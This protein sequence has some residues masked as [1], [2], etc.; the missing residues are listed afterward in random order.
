MHNLSMR[1][2]IITSTNLSKEKKNRIK[3]LVT[4][5]GASYSDHLEKECTH[6]ISET[7]RSQKYEV[8]SV[9]Q[10]KVMHP[11]WVEKVWEKSQKLGNIP[12]DD[13]EF[14][15]FLLPC[16]N[17]VC[18]TSTG[19]TTKERDKLKNLIEE[20]GGQYNATFNN[21]IDMLLMEASSI[22]T[23]KYNHAIR[24]K[25]ICL[26]PAWVYDSLK[27]GYALRLEKYIFEDKTLSVPKPIKI[28]TP[29]KE[30]TTINKF[31]PDSTM[32]SDLSRITTY[33]RNDSIDETMRTVASSSSRTLI[34]ASREQNGLV[35]Q[36]S[37]KAAKVAGTVLDGFCFYMSGFS[38]E[39]LR[40]LGKVLGILGATKVDTLD[41][42][43]S[44]VLVNEVNPE[45]FEELANLDNELSIVKIDW[46]KT[47][48]EQKQLVNEEEFL[49]EQ[50]ARRRVALEKP[51]PASKKAIERL[52]GTFKK[53]IIPKL[54]LDGERDVEENVNMVN[55]YLNPST[56]SE[57]SYNHSR[58]VKFLTGK[59]I[60]VYGCSSSEESMEIIEKVEELGATLVDA[61]FKNTVDYIITPNVS[62]TSFDHGIKKF[63]HLV[64][65]LWLVES[66]EAGSICDVL[67][68]HKP[69]VEYTFGSEELPL[70]NEKIA[71]T[72]YKGNSRTQIESLVKALGGEYSETLR[73]SD[74]AILISPDAVGKKC[75]SAKDWNFT[76]IK[77]EWLV[78][79]YE[80]RRRVNENPFLVGGTNPS[81]KNIENEEDSVVLSSQD[82]LS[83]SHR[84]NSFDPQVENFDDDDPHSTPKVNRVVERLKMTE[85]KTPSPSSEKTS[86]YVSEIINGMPTPVREI[87]RAV[88]LEANAPNSSSPRRKRFQEITTTPGNKIKN[89]SLETPELLRAPLGDFVLRPNASP[90]SQWHQK[91][92][93]EGLDNNYVPQPKKFRIKD[94]P[95]ETPTVSFS[96]IL[97]NSFKLF[98]YF[99]SSSAAIQSSPS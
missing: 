58:I 13:P 76:I 9:N 56:S 81:K 53:P 70:G 96:L 40:H 52:N 4:Y 33:Q 57:S 98:V 15:C 63:K 54:F 46:I 82:V 61:T 37:I 86:Q 10:T 97:Q 93:L 1:G 8:A 43:I 89:I 51:S 67:F 60:F 69:L 79:C 2:F 25:K 87:T 17:G 83:S 74:N 30:N 62:A 26:T 66:A 35:Q 5:M 23:L 88:L 38:T 77:A 50:P 41:H 12:A 36:I 47:M 16:F 21:S 3:E 73:K 29:T 84:F 94:I 80:K 7:V 32:L 59:N 85:I 20:N 45:L 48:I 27:I 14:D 95:Q 22:G 42:Q 65:M 24:L 49:V 34:P 64:N 19:L 68:Y 75:Q 6:L 39:E 78:E 31:Y 28:S 18:F 55:Q 11:N 71:V 99:V 72:N 92:K 90:E 44:H 91:R